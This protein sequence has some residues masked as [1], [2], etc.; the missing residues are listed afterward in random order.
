MTVNQFE[1]K[2]WLS[3]E[4]RALTEARESFIKKPYKAEYRKNLD[5]VITRRVLEEI[6]VQQIAA[7]ISEE[8]PRKVV[9]AYMSA[10]RM[11]FDWIAYDM[12]YSLR[13]ICRFYQAG[14]NELIKKG[15]LTDAE[16]PSETRCES[17][18][19]SA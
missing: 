4:I 3:C 13:Q 10:P 19:E 16:K 11:T 8:N 12:N 1:N 2:R 6:E 14:I 18:S 7:S 17:A 9:A 5:E 15:I